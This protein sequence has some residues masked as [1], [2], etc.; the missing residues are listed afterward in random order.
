MK[1]R[2]IFLLAFVATLLGSLATAAVAIQQ[3]R[4]GYVPMPEASPTPADSSLPRLEF[5]PPSVT[6]L[7]T[8]GPILFDLSLNISRATISRG[9][10]NCIAVLI[11]GLGETNVSLTVEAEG[12]PGMVTFPTGVKANFDM[13]T[14]VTRSNFTATTNLMVHVDNEALSGVYRLRIVGTQTGP[15][16]F[17]GMGVPLEITV[18]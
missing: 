8:P 4:K 18:Q 16:W 1:N 13:N 6:M 15:G 11:H 10:S 7:P 9:Q 14:I 17:A 5:P 3:S 12:P 2:M